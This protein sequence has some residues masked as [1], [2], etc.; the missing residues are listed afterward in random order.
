MLAILQDFM[1]KIFWQDMQ[2]CLQSFKFCKNVFNPS[3]FQFFWQNLKQIWMIQSH[4]YLKCFLPVSSL[5]SALWFSPALPCSKCR[6]NDFSQRPPLIPQ[7]APG[8]TKRDERH[9]K[10][11][12]VWCRF[13]KNQFTFNYGIPIRFKRSSK[14]LESFICKTSWILKASPFLKVMADGRK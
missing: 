3:N 2:K 10:S 5:H 14:S 7:A 6:G 12:E 9:E 4:P 11:R 8:K 1:Q 13:V